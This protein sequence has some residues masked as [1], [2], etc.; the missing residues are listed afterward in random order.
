MNRLFDSFSNGLATIFGTKKATGEEL[1]DGGQALIDLSNAAEGLNQT[2]L[3]AVHDAF[4]LFSDIGDLLPKDATVWDHIIHGKVYFEQLPDVFGYL[5]QS[6]NKLKGISTVDE[7]RE[8]MLKAISLMREM[9]ILM[10]TINFASNLDTG[11]DG[12]TAFNT[13]LTSLSRNDFTYSEN[14]LDA[15]AQRI[16]NW[17]DYFNTAFADAAPGI[18]VSPIITAICTQLVAGNEKVKLAL[19][20]MAKLAGEDLGDSDI[21]NLLSSYF[22]SGFGTGNMDQVTEQVSGV[23]SNWT[24]ELVPQ[25]DQAAMQDQARTM[26]EGLLS[27]MQGAMPEGGELEMDYKLVMIPS[28]EDLDNFA[29]DQNGTIAISGSVSIDAETVASITASIASETAK[30]TAA[31]HGTTAAV[32][33]LTDR[34][35]SLEDAIRS[36]KFVLGV[37]EVSDAVDRNLGAKSAGLNRTMIAF[38]G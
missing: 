11:V 8:N 25:M 33:A 13:F 3:Q 18:D 38:G 7:E 2:N 4:E 15:M 19:T 9:A 6:I 23:M 14:N 29:F 20:E 31:V 35:D 24:D 37:N 1:K 17:A 34:I 27:E 30:T 22:T 12:L 10:G 16:G 26:Y 5:V 32:N 36:M 28:T 21:M